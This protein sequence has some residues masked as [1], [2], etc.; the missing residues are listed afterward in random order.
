MQLSAAPVL[1]PGLRMQN[2]IVGSANMYYTAYQGGGY[3]HSLVDGWLT[4]LGEPAMANELKVNEA[5]V[6]Y[7]APADSLPFFNRVSFPTVHTAGW[8]DIFLGAQLIAFSGYATQ[9][10]LPNHAFLIVLPTGH[11]QMGWAP[12]PSNV[13]DGV[14]ASGAISEALMAASAQGH[15]VTVDASVDRIALYVMGNLAGGPGNYWT[16]AKQFPA[17]T[18]QRL[19]LGLDGALGAE[20][21]GAG[22][23][24]FLYDPSNPVPSVGGDNLMLPLCG[25]WP[26]NNVTARPDVLVFTGPVLSEDTYLCGPITASLSVSSSAVDTDFTVKLMDVFPDGRQML[27]QDGIVRMRWRDGMNGSPQ[28]LLPGSLYAVTV[29]LWSTTYVLAKGHKVALAVSSS[30]FPRFLPNLN[31]G[32]LIAQGGVPVTANNTVH[33]G[34]GSYLSLPVVAAADLPERSVPLWVD[35]VKLGIRASE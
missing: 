13:G 19:Y 33:F 26:Q 1:F 4:G 25:A 32:Q 22:S 2:V 3:R 12:W 21:P 23:A 20:P 24:S 29:D 14:A 35:A 10:A 7:W 15:R 16:T 11:C 30:N 34:P 18:T 8:W 28:W 31:N 5:N 17:P 9:A 6:E 27:L